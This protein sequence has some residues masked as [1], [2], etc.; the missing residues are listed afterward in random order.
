MHWTSENPYYERVVMGKIL[1]MKEPEETEETEVKDS[2][3][4][5]EGVSRSQGSERNP[6]FL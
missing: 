4:P 5:L 3:H 1:V 6:R 2:V